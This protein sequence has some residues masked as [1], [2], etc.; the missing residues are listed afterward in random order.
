MGALPEKMQTMP[1][2]GLS[3]ISASRRAL[4]SVMFMKN[5]RTV[6]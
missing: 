3:A 5:L 4:S 1:G 2:A 6:I